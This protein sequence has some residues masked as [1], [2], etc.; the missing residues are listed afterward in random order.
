MPER[1]MVVGGGTMGA[2]IALVAAGEGFEVTIVEP[3]ASARERAVASF[4]REAKRSGDASPALR[5]EWAD[6]IEPRDGVL[7]AIEAVP[8]LFELKRDVFLELAKSLAADALLASN[9]SS[10]SV[11]ELAGIAPNPARVIGLHFFNPPTRMRLVEVVQA[12]Q[13][14]QEAIDRAFEFVERW[15]RRRFS[16][17]ILRASS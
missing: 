15:V 13:T 2:G 11:G 16:S 7:L 3:Q 12:Q 5:I 4:A 14:A 10:F 6:R 17:R 8:E 9:T 1:V